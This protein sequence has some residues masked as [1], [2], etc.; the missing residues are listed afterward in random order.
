MLFPVMQ[1]I[2]PYQMG[3]KF[4][5]HQ[6]TPYQNIT[7]QILK[8]QKRGS[9]YDKAFTRNDN[10]INLIKEIEKDF[11]EIKSNQNKLQQAVWSLQASGQPLRMSM[12][13]RSYGDV[14]KGT[15]LGF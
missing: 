15:L 9:A 10:V 11:L 6:M 5:P 14:H 1:P 12:G 2:F 4:V 7:L 3:I 8:D 13:G